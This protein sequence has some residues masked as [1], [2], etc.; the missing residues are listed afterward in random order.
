MSDTSTF[1][2]LLAAGPRRQ[3]LLALRGSDSLRVP[4]ELV[5]ERPADRPVDGESGARSHS[6]SGV[7]D[8][9]LYHVH[10]PKLEAA[11]VVEWNRERRTVTRGPAFAA[12]EPGLDLLAE[13]AE[14]LPD[15]AF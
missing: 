3:V 14:K 12:V 1:F 8:V 5:G 10:L 6:G 4:D 2:D 11:G 7:D 9:R 15:A 13:N